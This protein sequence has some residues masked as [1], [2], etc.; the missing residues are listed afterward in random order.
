METVKCDENLSIEQKILL[1]LNQSASISD[2]YVFAQRFAL[3]HQQ[4]IGILK[5]LHA[6]YLIA[7]QLHSRGKWTLTEE[8]EEVRSRGSPESQVYKIV[9][10]RG[11]VCLKD[12]VMS[13]LHTMKS[14][15]IGEVKDILDAGKVVDIFSK[16][17]QEMPVQSQSYDKMLEIALCNG[18]RTKM[19]RLTKRDEKLWIVCGNFDHQD[20]IQ[21]QCNKV[22]YGRVENLSKKELEILKKRQLV[23][24]EIQKY[25]SVIK[26]PKFTL[27]RLKLE[28]D[29]TKRML[30]TESWRNTQ[31]KP[32]D[33]S[34]PGVP[35]SVGALH[36]LTKVRQEYREHF[37]ELGFQEMRT[38]F[39]VESSFWNFD[40]LFVPQL[41][42][43]RDM[44]DTFYL[45]HPKNSDESIPQ[46][47]IDSVRGVHEEGAGVNSLGYKYKWSESES[48]KNVLRTHTTAVTARKLYQIAEC[49]RRR[50]GKIVPGKYFSI[51]RVFRNEE[52]DKT[53]LCE[54][55]QVEGF[56]I[57][58]EL[59]LTQMMTILRDFFRK[60]GVEDLRFKPAYNPYTEPSMELFSFHKGHRKWV[61]V[62][63]SGIFRPELLRPMGFASTVTAIAWGLSL[64]RP[65]M[66]KYGL[67]DIHELMGS[68]VD[69]G[70]IKR[71][72]ICRL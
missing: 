26:G 19:L 22:R 44:Q 11:G 39:F 6:A 41:H 3:D 23:N 27:E 14:E 56:I 60:V 67:H 36:P 16:G 64:E 72:P 35:P 28:A 69:L 62:G 24:Y 45:S 40:A 15:H 66:V 2:S 68:K 29:L 9:S 1:T 51:D 7:I 48:R 13:I 43:A 33:F 8:G 21:E 54:F 57:D 46:D 49:A 63:N 32:Y 71:S 31:F 10:E 65:T 50:A 53:H 17:E 58:E 37:L 61:E 5:S 70:F 34:V 38:N 47:Y 42:P 59:S 12:E 30:Q 55:Y 4:L 20:M 25:F 52:M 18:L